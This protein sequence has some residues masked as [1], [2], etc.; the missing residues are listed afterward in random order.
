[1]LVLDIRARVLLLLV[2][3]SGAFCA[4]ATFPQRKQVSLQSLLRKYVKRDG[5]G[6]VCLVG[7]V[8]AHCNATLT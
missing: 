7:T 4:E 5:T 2:K 8:L 6:Y 1:M 3:P